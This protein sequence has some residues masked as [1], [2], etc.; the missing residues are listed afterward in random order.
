MQKQVDLLIEQDWSKNRKTLQMLN[1]RRE[2]GQLDSFKEEYGYLKKTHYNIQN[3]GS[4][5]VEDESIN[6]KSGWTTFDGP[7]LNSLLPW[8]KQAEELFKELNL[9]L[10][11]WITIDSI[12]PL[13]SD[14][15][16]DKKET[17]SKCRIN[18]IVTSED[19][20]AVTISYDRHDATKTWSTPSISGTAFLLDIGY[21]HEVKNDKHREIISFTF[22]NS[23]TIISEFLDKLGPIRFTE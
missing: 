9:E 19:P 8:V 14:I 3:V 11:Q 10:I 18:F 21:P 2:S 22:K 1:D 20:D 4:L 15:D 5:G 12:L 16:Y 6:E 13:H 17:G 23:Y 7:L